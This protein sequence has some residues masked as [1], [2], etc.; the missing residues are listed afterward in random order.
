MLCGNGGGAAGVPHRHGSLRTPTSQSLTVTFLQTAFQAGV[1]VFVVGSLSLAGLAVNVRGV[2]APLKHTRFVVLTLGLGWL[3]CPAV[4]Y[5]LIRLMPVAPPYETGLLLLSLAPGAPFAPAIARAARADAAYTAA[6]IALTSVAT[7]VL[8]P[9]GVTILIPGTTTDPGVIARPLLWFVCLPLLA[10]VLIRDRFPATADRMTPLLEGI[11]RLSGAVLLVLM[12][13][14]Y[15]R[16]V[17]ETFGS[18]AILTLLLFLVAVTVVTD[19]AGAALPYSQRGALTIGMCTRN[20]GA[21]LAPAAVI[22]PDPRVIVMIVI[23]APATLAVGVAAAR[24]LAGRA[25]DRMSGPVPKSHSSTVMTMRPL[26]T[27]HSEPVRDT[28][29]DAP[30]TRE[31]SSARRIAHRR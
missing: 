25:A 11:T 3:L 15:G 20:L 14:L 18:F 16:G 30:R 13:V 7:V 12:C 22:D 2:L 19:V 10:G 1:I 23:A 26:A 24:M 17:L 6:F 31:L 21:A 4:A 27:G 29:H 8:M 5:G 9:L 28:S